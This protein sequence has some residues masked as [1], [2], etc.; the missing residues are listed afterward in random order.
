VGAHA[1]VEEPVG[2]ERPRRQTLLLLL[3]MGA[4]TLA[5][6]GCGALGYTNGKANKA[7]GKTLFQQK[8]GGC[9]TLADA[10]TT[11]T[12]GPDLDDAFRVDRQQGMTEDTVRQVVRAQ[13]AYAITTTSTGAPGMPKNIV[14]GQD[15]KDVAA[16][17]ASV[18]G[19]TAASTPAPA[20]T[21][22]PTPTTTSTPSTTTTATSG[23][24]SAATLAL[25][26]SV[27]ASNAC[28]GCHTLKD[29]GS[30]GN[31]GPVL[32]NLPADAKKA[33]QDEAAYIKA[34]IVTPN[35]YIV[36]GFPANTMPT[37]FAQILKPNQLDAL[38]AYLLAVAGK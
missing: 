12:I 35:A 23:A 9:H 7:N 18:A 20:P 3:V 14:T 11:G 13:I 31:I 15:A 6:A 28:G 16:Y 21:P 2:G 17:V 37:N 38:V 25:G 30:G 22:T 10:G 34:S 32:D 4:A 8:C 24:P 1:R 19:V 5:L 27:F 26:K 29:A 33:G 36:P